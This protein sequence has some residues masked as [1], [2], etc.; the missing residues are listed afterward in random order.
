MVTVR[1]R[2]GT[3]TCPLSHSSQSQ[4]P[5]SAALETS[6][7]A[8]A[9]MIEGI[10]IISVKFFYFVEKNVYFCDKTETI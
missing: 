10:V 8:T 7:K 6:V 5:S 4:S 2:Q 9:M 1:V 3:G